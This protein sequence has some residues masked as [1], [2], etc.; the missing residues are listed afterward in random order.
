MLR[1]ASGSA[2]MSYGRR[3][4]NGFVI[5]NPSN[6]TADVDVV[7]EGGPYIDPTTN[8]SVTKL[9]VAPQTAHILLKSWTAGMQQ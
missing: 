1:S 6:E 3:F 8:K 7:L 5:Y 9:D 4:E 2:V